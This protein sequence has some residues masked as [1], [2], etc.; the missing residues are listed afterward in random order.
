MAVQQAKR[1]YI[2]RRQTIRFQINS[3]NQARQNDGSRFENKQ[4][5]LMMK[6]FQTDSGN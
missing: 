1:Y 5:D 6:N 2:G 3:P 4:E